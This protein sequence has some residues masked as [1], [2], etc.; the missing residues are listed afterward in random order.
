MWPRAYAHTE[1]I[2]APHVCPCRIRS[3]AIEIG[4]RLA[5]AKN[6]AG[7]GEWLPWLKNEFGWTHET[8]GKYMDIYKAVASGKLNFGVQFELPVNSWALLAAPSTPEPARAEVVQRAEAGEHLTHA[9]VKE[10]VEKAPEGGY[11][12][13]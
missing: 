13:P 9:Q 6:I 5:E 2:R 1:H 11:R 4:R 10:I 8:A 12:K 3:K 7:H